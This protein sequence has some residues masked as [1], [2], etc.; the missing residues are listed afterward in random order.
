LQ[1]TT[2]FKIQII[3]WIIF[4]IAIAIVIAGTSLFSWITTGTS[5]LKWVHNLGF[6]SILFA[7]VGC[8][9]AGIGASIRQKEK[10]TQKTTSLPPPPP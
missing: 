5:F 3:G 1:L 9:I 7:L 2:G 8:G 4:L 6:I 10:K